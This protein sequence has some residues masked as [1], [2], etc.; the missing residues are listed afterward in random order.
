MRAATQDALLRSQ[1]I[2]DEI[3]TAV[4]SEPIRVGHATVDVTITGTNDDD[5]ISW[6]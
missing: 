2:A 6:Q 3:R 1:K 4:R 5:V